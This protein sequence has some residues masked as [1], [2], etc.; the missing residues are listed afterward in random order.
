MDALNMDMAAMIALAAPTVKL[1][2]ALLAAMSVWSWALIFRL[3]FAVRAAEGRLRRGTPD[4]ADTPFFRAEAEARETIAAVL[5][6]PGDVE[7]KERRLERLLPKIFERGSGEEILAV[8]PGLGFLATCSASAPFIG[9]FGTVWG[10]M[11]AFHAL[12]Q[13]RSV[14]LASV[15]PGISEALLATAL[16][17][18]TAIPATIAYNR[19]SGR[20][21]TLEAGMALHAQNFLLTAEKQLYGDA[22]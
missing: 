8:S 14:V 9:L 19:F 16:G 17:L 12:G 18:F 22:S 2:M 3:F 13:T 5:D 7:E 6:R 21:D 1:V 4:R 20:L 10:V 11:H 15:A